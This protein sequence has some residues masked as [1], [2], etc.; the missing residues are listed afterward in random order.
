VTDY[1]NDGSL[2]KVIQEVLNNMKDV[3]TCLDKSA[4]INFAKGL[5]LLEKSWERLVLVSKSSEDPNLMHIAANLLKSGSVSDIYHMYTKK[6]YC[7]TQSK[8]EE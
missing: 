3:L 7:K 5:N 8:N 1:S 2:G 6:L 4:I